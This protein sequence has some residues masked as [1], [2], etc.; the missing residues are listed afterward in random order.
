MSDPQLEMESKIAA[1]E[2]N[3]R[4]LLEEMEKLTHE[5]ELA[6]DRLASCRHAFREVICEYDVSGEYILDLLVFNYD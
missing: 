6:Q 1:L 4:R 3:R 5:K 2:A